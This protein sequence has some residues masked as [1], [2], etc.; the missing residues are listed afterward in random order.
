MKML[1]CAASAVLVLLARG[2]LAQGPVTP[3]YPSKPVRILVGFAPGGGIDIVARIYAQ[4]LTE[5]VGQSFI[6]DNRPGAGGTI[7]T[8]TLAKAPPDG[9]T[10]IMVSVTHSINASLYSKLPYDTVKAFSPVTPVALQAD[11][12]AVHPSMPVKSLRDLIGL[13]KSKPGEVSY[14]HAGNGTLMHVGMELFLSMAGI[15]M[16]AVPYNGSGP[17]T[18]ATLGGQ[19][20]VLSTSLPPSLPHAKAGKLRLLA[21]TTAQRTPL[22]PEYPTVEEAAG[23]KG[24]EAVVWIGLLAPAGTPAAVINKLNSE[25]ERLQQTRELREQMA[26][27]GTDPYRD[28]PAG[29]AELIRKDVVKWGKIVHDTGLKAE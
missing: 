1:G 4:R 28:T 12:I 21:V 3:A 5:S 23:L 13:A 2:A 10:L 22:A 15:K 27:Q 11:V 7:A 6:V 19:V 29:F 14:A 18:V 25:V 20:P 8:D 17:S 24:Y 9:Y 26:K 16:L